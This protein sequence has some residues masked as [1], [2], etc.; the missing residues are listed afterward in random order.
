MGLHTGDRPTREGYVGIDVHR[1]PGR[2]PPTAARSR[3]PDDAALLD[4]HALRDSRR[5]I[6]SRTSTGRPGSFQLGDGE[7][8]PRDAGS[9]DLPTPATRFLG[10]EPSSSRRSPVFERDPR[11]LTIVGPGGTG[12]TRFAI[13]LA[14]LLADEADGGTVFFRSP[15]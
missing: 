4:R 5:C 14:R 13:E 3:L 6:G 7:F 1:G 2:A 11:V 10:R 12:K 9:V 8:P 15:A